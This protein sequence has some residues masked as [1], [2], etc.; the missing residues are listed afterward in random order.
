MNKALK[1]VLEIVLA[2]VA[3]GLAY[4]LVESI[5]K[6]VNFD[7]EKAR[8]EQVGIQRLKD[9][10]TLQVAFKSVN[11]H[12]TADMDSL[13]AFYESSASGAGRTSAPKLSEGA[14]S[15]PTLATGETP[16]SAYPK[17][18]KQSFKE[19]ADAAIIVISRFGGESWDVPRFQDTENGGIEGHHYL[20]LD[21]NEYDLLDMVTE[22]FEKVIVLLNTTTSFQCDFLDEYNNVAGDPRIDAVL[23]IGRPGHTGAEVIGKILTG[24]ISPSGR[25][26]DL[27]SKDF[28]KDPTWQNFGDNSQVNDGEEGSAFLENGTP[29]PGKFLITYEEGIYMGYRYYETRGFEEAE[30]DAQS[31]WYEDNVR[32][33]F[34]YGLSYTTFTQTIDS[35][36]GDLTSAD[37]R[38]TVTV[39]SVPE[40]PF[41]RRTMLSCGKCTPAITLSST[42]RRRSPGCRPTFSEGPPEMTSRTMAVSFGT[43]NWIPIPSKLPASSVSVLS[44]SAGGR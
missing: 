12:F 37:S 27:Y 1:T 38:I 32:F 8:R 18:L 40:G 30:K 21:Q 28:T 42:F 14:G 2:L 13:K 4:L 25:V 35:I 29:L 9:I 34:G 39:T 15:S 7:K 3:V 22:R 19:Y 20:Q 5:K 26:M 17:E 36:T 43:L 31:T 11:N 24:E 44:S 23:W 41:M 33:P 16:V 6:P 10:R